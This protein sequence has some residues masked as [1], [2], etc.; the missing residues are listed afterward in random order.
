VLLDLFVGVADLDV[1]FIH[2]TLQ[3]AKLFILL[4][5]RRKG[6]KG[7]GVSGDTGLEERRKQHFTTS[8]PA[9]KLSTFTT[10]MIIN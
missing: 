2:P 7:A 5:L 8:L 3:P 9:S 10:L 4:T 6:M 1:E